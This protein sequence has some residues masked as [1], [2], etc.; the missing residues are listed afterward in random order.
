MST[1]QTLTGSETEMH[2]QRGPVSGSSSL[3]WL[4]GAV[5]QGAF[6]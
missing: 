1:A 2:R 3:C 6:S 5:S 4:L